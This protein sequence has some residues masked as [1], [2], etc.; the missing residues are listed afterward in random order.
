MKKLSWRRALF[1]LGAAFV[2]IA[3]AAGFTVRQSASDI[4]IAMIA[5]L[6]GPYVFVG[7]PE[8]DAATKAVD[9]INAK[10]GIQG[11]KLVMDVFDDASS[12]P[13]SVQLTQQVLSDSKYVAVIGTGFGSAALADEPLA[14][15][16]ILYIS[17]AAPV[18]QVQPA[19]PSIY[20]VP[21]NSRLFAY[22]MA[23][24]LKKKGI[25]NIALLQDNGAYPTEGTRNVKEYA[26]NGRLNIVDDQTFTLTTTDF[27]A[28]L[29]K[30]KSES[31]QAI[32]L[33][34]LPQATAV[35]KQYRQLNINK[36]LVLTG[37]NATPQYLAPN[38]ACPDAN[39]ALI[40]SPV[41]QVAKF[42]P[43][44]NPSRAIALHVDSIMGQKGNQFYYDGYSAV[45][46]IKAGLI[47][48]GMTTDRQKLI[49]TFESGVK[50]VGAEG[51]WIF[52]GSKHAGLGLSDLV[53]SKIVNC[54][55]KPVPGQAVFS[56]KKK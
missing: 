36:L 22:N 34:N 27:T 10:G 9:E 30:L 38:A 37:G 51:V 52:K 56:T 45:N 32:W 15:G 17:E 5:P 28:I 55:Y 29:T 3:V 2:V 47:K 40:N 26:A 50:Y 24:Y 4:H 42:L 19:K 53:V 46:I 1:A 12:P 20:M 7:G 11:H 49:K 35:T 18:A 8:R 21:P 33:W 54:G 14:S 23:A 44:T 41:A 16:Q 31:E 6:T 43:K 48:S 13:Q 25:K 39:G